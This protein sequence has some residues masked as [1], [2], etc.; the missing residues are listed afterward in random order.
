M[1]R[2]FQHC[3][4]CP[5]KQTFSV[6][7]DILNLPFDLPMLLLYNLP[8]RIYHMQ[9]QHPW[10]LHSYLQ[11]EKTADRRWPHIQNGKR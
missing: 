11:C 10:L 9:R 6:Q 7:E 4:V 5:G 8:Y 1:A 3:R 2:D